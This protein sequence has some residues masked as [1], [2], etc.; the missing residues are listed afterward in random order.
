MWRHNSEQV[1]MYFEKLPPTLWD[2]MDY[3]VHGILQARKLE[4]VAI[5]FSRAPSQPRDRTQVSWIAHKFFNSWATRGLVAREVNCVTRRLELS[6][7][8]PWPMGE[9]RGSPLPLQPQTE[10]ITN[11]QSCNQLCPCNE[12]SIKP[13]KDRIQ[14]ASRLVNTWKFGER[15][16][17][18]EGMEAPPPFPDLVPSLPFGWSWVTS[19]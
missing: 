16:L 9:G 19:F 6:V 7:A 8:L 17:L 11:G 18:A 10:S 12:V 5:P 3:T 13:P 14:R 4:W 1:G 2:P 15:S